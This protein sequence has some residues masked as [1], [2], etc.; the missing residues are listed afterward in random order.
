VIGAYFSHAPLAGEF[1]FQSYA[2]LPKSRAKTRRKPLAERAAQHG[3]LPEEVGTLDSER[4]LAFLWQV[5]GRPVVHLEGWRRERPLVIV[6]DNYSV[7]QS[8]LVQASL[9]E[10]AAADVYLFYLPAYRP[11]LSAIE[12]IWHA[13]K[14]QEL[15]E[16][17]FRLLGALKRAVDAAL[18]R[19]ATALR[20]GD[21]HS[22]QSL[23]L[24][25]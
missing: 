20:A 21:A 8:D 23:P 19:K 18:T 15:T 6:L 4:C 11:E 5:A 16:R 10:L 3:L 12:P 7:H 25:A 13:V 22:D 24:A 17:S 14:H 1:H 9:A 2:S